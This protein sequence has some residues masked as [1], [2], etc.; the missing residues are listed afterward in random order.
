MTGQHRRRAAQARP[1][2]VIAA[3]V[4]SLAFLAG[5][6]SH[7]ATEVLAPSD[8]TFINSVNPDNN[9]GGSGS[10]FT[11]E[12]GKG[13]LM[14]ALVRFPMPAGLQGR[15][16]V[17][18]VQLSLTVQALPFNET[19]ASPGRAGGFHVVAAQSGWDGGRS[20]AALGAT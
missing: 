10:L 19:N 15:V 17:T 9:N 14:R 3:C 5:R 1:H 11:G 16:S 8:D 12:D 20:R 6:A 2:R 18:G 7:A 13:G 4:C